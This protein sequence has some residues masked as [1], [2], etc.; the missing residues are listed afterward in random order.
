MLTLAAS[1]TYLGRIG[2][3]SATFSV[4][5]YPMSQ[6]L[7][8]FQGFITHSEDLT[9][10]PFGLVGFHEFTPLN[11]RFRFFSSVFSKALS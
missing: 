4:P 3:I 7:L 6:Y 11:G 8:R 5:L 9:H 10:F 2:C 1:H